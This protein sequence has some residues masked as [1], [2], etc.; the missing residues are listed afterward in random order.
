V[1][2]VLA[3]RG[4]VKFQ[5]QGHTPRQIFDEIMRIRRNN[6]LLPNEAAVWE[7][8][9]YTWCRRDPQRCGGHQF[10]AETAAGSERKKLTP[11]DYGPWVWR[12][13][14]TFGIVFE[15]ERFLS[16]V[17][18]AAA[19]LDPRQSDAGCVVCH[20]HFREARKAWPPEQVGSRTEAAVWVWTVHNLA[21]A[22]SQHRQF[23]FS[24][25]A[26][27]YGWELLEGDRVAGIQEK[28]KAPGA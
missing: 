15:K 17:E 7:W 26:R 13:L 27:V 20:E 4:G 6:G 3:E 24:E 5:I 22:H 28:L 1:E 10:S 23:T 11:V 12:W 18:Q 16:A 2:Y 8:L 21:N 14:N 19:L 9:N 25:I